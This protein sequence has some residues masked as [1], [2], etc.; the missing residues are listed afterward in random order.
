[1]EFDHV[2]WYFLA[3]ISPFLVDGPVE[4]RYFG[5]YPVDVSEEENV[6]EEKDCEHQVVDVSAE[7]NVFG[8]HFPS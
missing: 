1:M 5:C 7:E 8:D 2:S 3:V 6:T 4:E